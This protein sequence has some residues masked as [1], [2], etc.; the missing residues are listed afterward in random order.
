MKMP[1]RYRSARPP[2]S[3]S[4]LQIG[5][6]ALG[7]QEIAT[8]SIRPAGN[9][10]QHFL[11]EVEGTRL[12]FRQHPLASTSIGKNF[13]QVL[14]LPVGKTLPGG[15]KPTQLFGHLLQLR[16]PWMGQVSIHKEIGCVR[17][18]GCL[19]KDRQQ[20]AS[21]AMADQHQ[22]TLVRDG[23]E[24]LLYTRGVLLPV[25][26]GCLSAISED[27]HQHI[28]TVCLQRLRNQRPGERTD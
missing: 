5:A 25:R 9:V 20:R 13:P 12:H 26:R 3:L 7:K 28:E 8:G 16:L 17:M 27:W 18:P 14:V 22:G 1:C 19:G 23:H 15:Q 24:R 6:I 21:S 4:L 11:K 10:W 2:G